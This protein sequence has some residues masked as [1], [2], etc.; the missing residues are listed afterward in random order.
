MGIE[1][2]CDR[3]WVL[4]PG[5]L[6]TVAVFDGLLDCLGVDARDRSLIQLDQPSVQDYSAVFDTLSEDAIVCGFSLGAIVAAHYADRMNVQSLMLFGLNPHADDLNKAAGRHALANDVQ[7][8]GGAT[9]LRDR[10][11]DV[12]GKN[13]DAARQTIYQ[14][15]DETA[16]LIDAQ[17]QLALTRPGALPSLAKAKMPVI[18][19]TGSQDAAAPADQGRAA[20]QA[21]PDGRFLSLEGLGHFALLEDPLACAMV[22]RT[23]TEPHDD[24]A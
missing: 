15:A 22:I 6:C 14:M 8:Y 23:M 3:P 17:T 18:C 20:A 11:P 4:L 1:G 10:A 19:F 24:I 13:P 2:L 12:G 9:A 16:H 7:A 5:T 21:A